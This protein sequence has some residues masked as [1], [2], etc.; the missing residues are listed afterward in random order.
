M[1][2]KNYQAMHEYD[3]AE[4]AFL[5]AANLVPNRLYPWYLLTKLYDEMGLKDK[6]Y[7]TATIVQTKEPKI[8]SP[9]IDE[10]REEVGKIRDKE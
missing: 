4:A 5:K 1:I 6:V 2:G 10:M 7:E 8:Q 9:A 3:L